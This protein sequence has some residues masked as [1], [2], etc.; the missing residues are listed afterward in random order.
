MLLKAL[1]SALSLAKLDLPDLRRGPDGA[2]AKNRV[3][4][5][6]TGKRSKQ[7]AR[8]LWFKARLKER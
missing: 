6:A 7:E 4:K 2:M 1:R 5:T 3:T 8:G